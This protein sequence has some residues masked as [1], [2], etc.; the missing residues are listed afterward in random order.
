LKFIKIIFLA[1]AL[2]LCGCSQKQDVAPSDTD[3]FDEEFAKR[4]VFD[5]LS[6]YN[7]MMTGFNDFMYV[8]AI[9]PAVKGYNYVVPEAARTAAGNF[10]DNLFLLLNL[11]DNNSS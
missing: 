1:A 10:F 8:N 6:G 9:H 7:R 11:K 2:A 4:E 5:P 3:G